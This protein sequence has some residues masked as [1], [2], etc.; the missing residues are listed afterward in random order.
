MTLSLVSPERRVHTFR[1]SHLFKLNRDINNAIFWALRGKAWARYGQPATV[2]KLV[3]GQ[4]RSLPYVGP[5]L[6]YDAVSVQLS[7]V[8]HPPK[9]LWEEG[10]HYVRKG[11][12]ACFAINAPCV[13]WSRSWKQTSATLSRS[14]LFVC[15][16]DE[17]IATA[18]RVVELKARE[19][20]T[21]YARDSLVYASQ[22]I[23]KDFPFVT[24]DQ[25]C[26]IAQIGGGPCRP[27]EAAQ[28]VAKQLL[29]YSQSQLMTEIKQLLSVR[30][31]E[32]QAKIFR[33]AEIR[34]SHKHCGH[35]DTMVRFLSAAEEFLFVW[36]SQNH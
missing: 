20:R 6:E 35:V 31:L 10:G 8:G 16:T 22:Q 11:T 1:S 12:F 29:V 36:M 5:D 27:L 13:V 9:Y 28:W 3:P 18:N 21:N 26:V 33:F 23:H 2:M 30:N 25:A 34:E 15:A 17:Q 14:Q 24:P 19:Y 4:T 7:F 32:Q